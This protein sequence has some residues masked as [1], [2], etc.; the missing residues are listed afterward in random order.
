MEFEGD[1]DAFC[2]WSVR[3]NPKR[4]GTE[5]KGVGNKWTSG[6]IPTT[7][8]LRLAKIQRSILETCHSNSS[9]KNH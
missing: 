6:D 7:A 5:T 8:L 3:Y 4:I 2:N 1:S 9:G